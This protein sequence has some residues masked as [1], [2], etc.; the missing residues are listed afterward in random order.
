MCNPAPLAPQFVSALQETAQETLIT[1]LQ[2]S[3]APAQ[4]VELAQN[5]RLFGEYL[6]AAQHSPTLANNF[7]IEDLA[8]QTVNLIVRSGGVFHTST[9]ATIPQEVLS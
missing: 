9:G 4:L 3:Q 7:G 8:I 2:T 5:L 6:N 1:Y